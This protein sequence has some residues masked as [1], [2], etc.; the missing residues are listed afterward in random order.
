MIFTNFN[1]VNLKVISK[2]VVTDSLLHAK[3]QQFS[4]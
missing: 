3:L 1:R 2:T 4:A